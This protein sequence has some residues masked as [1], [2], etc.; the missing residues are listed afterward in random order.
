VHGLAVE[1]SCCEEPNYKP[2]VQ[3]EKEKKREKTS[4]RKKSFAGLG[5]LRLF[6]V[7]FPTNAIEIVAFCAVLPDFNSR[8]TQSCLLIQSVLI[9][10]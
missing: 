9:R 7:I 5:V 2:N 8:R 10:S 1:Q 3:D 6:Y 4:K